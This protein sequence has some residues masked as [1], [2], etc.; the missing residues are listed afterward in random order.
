[1]PLA[2]P[3]DG[4]LLG[5]LSLGVLL[6]GVSVG[7]L[8]MELSLVQL[9]ASRAAD[10]AATTLA[11]W[12]PVMHLRRAANIGGSRSNHNALPR[13]HERSLRPACLGPVHLSGKRGP[14]DIREAL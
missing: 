1:L 6:L 2:A 10:N 9:A 11:R 7:A 5:V 14:E 13:R 3:L 4:V 12:L 8:S